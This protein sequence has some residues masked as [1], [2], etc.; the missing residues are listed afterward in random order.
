[1]TET[2]LFTAM[3]ECLADDRTSKR[4]TAVYACLVSY[5]RGNTS[6]PSRKRIAKEA[7]ISYINVSRHTRKLADCGY[8]EIK[9]TK[10]RN[11]NV[12]AL[13]KLARMGVS[14]ARVDDARM[15]ITGDTG[16]NPATVDL[17]ILQGLE[18][19]RMG[20][21]GDTL[22]LERASN[23][24][25]AFVIVS[26]ASQAPPKRVA[27]LAGYPVLRVKELW[28]EHKH[29]IWLNW[30]ATTETRRH[31][32]TECLLLFQEHLDKKIDDAVV[33]ELFEYLSTINFFNGGLFKD[34]GT[35]FRLSPSYLF[36]NADRFARILTGEWMDYGKPADYTPREK[37][38]IS[39]VELVEQAIRNN[40]ARD[41]EKTRPR[42]KQLGEGS[43]TDYGLGDFATHY[44]EKA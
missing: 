14:D 33:V 25:D 44:G 28:D 43:S 20:I 38:R 18:T 21:T 7:R 17:S 26:E 19:S 1:M 30:G 23:N 5:A 4:D 16:V 36:G 41:K 24:N 11:T 37:S 29:E 3:R 22:S 2:R 8:V 35:K 15:G 39:A 12:Y 31:Q 13:P 40:Q 32:V 9:P 27:D 6:R 34:D 10:G 42:R